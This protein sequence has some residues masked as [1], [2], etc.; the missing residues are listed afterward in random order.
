M[1]TTFSYIE[2]ER[3]AFVVFLFIVFKKKNK[4]R[5]VRKYTLSIFFLHPGISN[6]RL[7]ALTYDI[8]LVL[9]AQKVCVIMVVLKSS[10]KKRMTDLYKTDESRIEAMSGKYHLYSYLLSFSSHY[11]I[12]QC[13]SSQYASIN[14]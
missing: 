2:K 6:M 3:L 7:L 5:D 10:N 14:I 8:Q 4:Y 1:V 13:I 12:F 11:T 9:Y